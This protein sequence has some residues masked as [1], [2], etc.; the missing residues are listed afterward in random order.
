MLK[1]KKKNLVKKGEIY[2]IKR[3]KY[4]K[5]ENYEFSFR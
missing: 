4:I 2:L 5:R 3:E 1:D